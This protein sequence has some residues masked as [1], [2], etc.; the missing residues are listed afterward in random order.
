M[1]RLL[2]T[3]FI[4]L[5]LASCVADPDGPPAWKAPP[6]Y[7]YTYQRNCFCPPEWRGPFSVSADSAS[8]VSVF[9]KLEGGDS[10]RITERLQSYSID[11]IRAELNGKLA[12]EHDTAIVRYDS[13]YGFPASA[14]I[15]F[16]HQMADEEYGFTI[17]DFRDLAP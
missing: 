9:R 2:G 11:S 3:A 10:V 1:M 4:A 14:Y 15:D 5:V 16:S 8:V 13:L 12:R 17:T 6:A 7:T